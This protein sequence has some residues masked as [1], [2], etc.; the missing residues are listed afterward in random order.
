MSAL[1]LVARFLM[2]SFL[3]LHESHKPSRGLW[4][5]TTLRLYAV[6]FLLLWSP[7][8]DEE[9]NANEVSAKNQKNASSI[10]RGKRGRYCNR[11]YWFSTNCLL[12]WH[13]NDVQS[14]ENCHYRMLCHLLQGTED[15]TF[16]INH[17]I[18]D[19]S[20][21][22]LN[23]ISSATIP[24]LG[25]RFIL[26]YTCISLLVI[27]GKRLVMRPYFLAQRLAFLPQ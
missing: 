25:I 4:S 2:Y 13:V 17:Y 26:S 9:K 22:N 23:R 10:K 8:I 27:Y 16:L 11:Q 19:R 5:S 3:P 7:M 21:H 24:A 20:L 15:R 1:S 6:T 12:R 14:G 18:T